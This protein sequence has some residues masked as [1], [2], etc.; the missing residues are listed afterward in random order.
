MRR[1]A[2][3]GRSP[4][5]VQRRRS[6]CTLVAAV[7]HL[8]VTIN[9]GRD[10]RDERTRRPTVRPTFMIQSGLV[11]TQ[12]SATNANTNCC[13]LQACAALCYAGSAGIRG[14][15]PLKAWEQRVSGG[16][17]CLLPRQ[18]LTQGHHLMT[19]ALTKWSLSFF[20]SCR[21]ASARST[22]MSHCSRIIL[23]SLVS[24]VPSPG[25]ENTA[26]SFRLFSTRRA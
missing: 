6:V 5:G 24:A 11:Y 8:T 22:R 19:P 21:V 12:R 15:F 10:E 18:I 4:S 17:L 3:N 13:S 7:S 14:P 23:A 26:P 25:E 1:Y 16:S 2:H 9:S 20:I